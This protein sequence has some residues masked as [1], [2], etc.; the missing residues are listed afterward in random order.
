M[1]SAQTARNTTSSYLPIKRI[2]LAAASIRLMDQGRLVVEVPEP[3]S[4][5]AGK[6]SRP[7]NAPS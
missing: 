5:C 1:C 7:G 2:E 6:P 4:L 3:A